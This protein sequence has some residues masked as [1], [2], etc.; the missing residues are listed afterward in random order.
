M[1]RNYVN[2]AI[3]LGAAIFFEYKHPELTMFELVMIYNAFLIGF[4]LWDINKKLH[5]D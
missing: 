4:C 1:L 5:E 2:A 3:A